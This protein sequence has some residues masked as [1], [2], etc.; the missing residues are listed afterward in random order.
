[1][2]SHAT[3]LEEMARR[4]EEWES[5][6]KAAESKIERLKVLILAAKHLLL[7]GR[8]PKERGPTSWED[9]RNRWIALVKLEEMTEH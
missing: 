8:G 6:C 2:N 4:E 5:A 9:T 3:F 7:G 1:M